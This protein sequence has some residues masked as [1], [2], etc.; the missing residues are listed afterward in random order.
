MEDR[1]KQR[2]DK[3]IRISWLNSRPGVGD[4]LAK[5]ATTETEPPLSLSCG[6]ICF[7]FQLFCRTDVIPYP[8]QLQSAAVLPFYTANRMRSNKMA[9]CVNWL[10]STESGGKQSRHRTKEGLQCL[11]CCASQRLLLLLV[12][13]FAHTITVSQYYAILRYSKAPEDGCEERVAGDGV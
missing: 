2:H 6:N 13:Q 10:C 7:R 8:L 3:I 4:L 9:D 12:E 1:I 11:I 5:H